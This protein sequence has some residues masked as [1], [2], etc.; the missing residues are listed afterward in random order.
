[1]LSPEYLC[2][3]S[4][5]QVC[6]AKAEEADFGG[7][8][9]KYF[10]KGREKHMAELVSA[11]A[12]TSGLVNNSTN[13]QV[14]GQ[15]QNLAEP[16]PKIE[17]PQKVSIDRVVQALQSYIDSNST[18]LDISVNEATGDIIVKVISDVDGKVIREIPPEEVMNRAAM[19]EQL[20]GLM[21][22]MNV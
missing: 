12:S 5:Q 17:A 11:I 9:H 20:E 7:E 21:F 8:I 3:F 22:D 13:Y 19:M 15:A 16:A 14:V 2:S 6:L 18:S 1:L 4:L 10:G